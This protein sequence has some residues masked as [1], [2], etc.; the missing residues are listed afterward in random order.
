MIVP[1]ILSGGRG[2]RLWPISRS[3]HPKQFID[4]VNDT[5]LFQD[6]ILR[7]PKKSLDPLI[8]CNEEHRFLAAEQLRQINK[9]SNGIILEPFGRSTA[10]AVAL[11]A[12]KLINNKKDPNLLVLS[13]DHYIED[14]KAFHNSIR[15]AESISESGKL[16]TF[17]AIPTKPETGYGYIEFDS[18]EDADY[19]N[20]KSF[21]EKPNL[22]NAKLF[23]DKGNYFW[24]SGIFM[25]KASAY[26]DE[27]KKYEPEIFYA[28]KKSLKITQNDYDFI[29]IDKNEF[30]SCPIKSIDYAVM[31]KTSNSV[32]IPLHTSWSDIGS[33]DSLWEFK[34]KDND[35]NVIKGDIIVKKVK[36]T[37][38]SSS[39]RLVAAIG[40][41]DLVII[42][43]E[44]SL[45]VANKEYS[46]KISTIVKEL[47]ENNRKEA[48]S[49]KKVYRPWGYYDSLDIGNYFQ[50]KRLSINPGSKIS[51]QKHKHRA[52]H[53]VVVQGLATI[54]CG[55]NIIELK[56]NQ[57]TYI[58]RNTI[59]RLENQGDTQ[60]E[61]IEIQTGEYLG[62]DDIIRLE[63]DYHR[64]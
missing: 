36:N 45:L 8:V 27:L 59:H 35:G 48:D 4:L 23:I 12:F 16:V 50:V 61:I 37:Y 5:T 1:I 41:N 62:E 55:E 30:N 18:S 31:E 42:D 19:Y 47:N 34:E 63:D 57:S 32:V 60:L 52:E 11:A 15:I 58:P 20:I 26:L 25:F 21:I 46:Q 9:K 24:N 29:R 14:E 56:R 44:D 22:I 3:L 7:L 40:V 17:G 49:H 2:T 53:W 13:A 64:N 33:W 38:V 43:T 28:C 10:P 39:N 51:L 6:A 54:I